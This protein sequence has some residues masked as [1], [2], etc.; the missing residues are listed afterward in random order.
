MKLLKPLKLS[1]TGLVLSGL[2]LSLNALAGHN[3]LA[4]L[5]ARIAPEGKLNV[6]ESGARADANANANAVVVAQSSEVASAAAATPDG[7]ATYQTA[8]IACHASGLAGAPRVGD[9]AAWQ[10]RLAQGMAVLVENAVNGFQGQSGVMPAKGGNPTL[11]D[12]AVEAA[13]QYMVE[14]SQ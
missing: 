3:T 2:A 7:Q 8:C 14:Q 1:L 5:Q 6:V 9:A 13:V 11:S 4:A 12:A 10:A